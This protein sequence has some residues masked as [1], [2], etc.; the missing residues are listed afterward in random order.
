MFSN[1]TA[2]AFYQAH[3][4]SE[5]LLSSWENEQFS[6]MLQSWNE[7]SLKFILHSYRM[8][9]ICVYKG[10]IIRLIFH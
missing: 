5:V 10:Y 1:D 3:D 7:E 4:S 6:G 8:V 9:F 2:T